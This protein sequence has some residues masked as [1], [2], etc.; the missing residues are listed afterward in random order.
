MKAEEGGIELET[1]YSVAQISEMWGLSREVIR[2]MFLDEPG[3][4]KWG[5]EETL[6]KRSYFTLRIPESVLRTVHKK[7]RNKLAIAA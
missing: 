3:V 1:H 6:S 2:D 7:H 5:A 4:L